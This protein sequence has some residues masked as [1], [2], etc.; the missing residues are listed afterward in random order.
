MPPRY[1]AYNQ[2]GQVDIEAGLGAKDLASLSFADSLIRAAFI[3]K[4]FGLLSV[5]LLLTTVIG[6]SFVSDLGGIKSFA[7]HNPIVPITCMLTT[8]A[9]IIYMGFN[10]KVRTLSRM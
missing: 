10:E 3:R 7:M 5:Q 9:V 2:Q 8:L 1:S 4:V 6:A